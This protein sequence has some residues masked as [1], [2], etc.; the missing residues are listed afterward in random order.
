MLKYLS[1]TAFF[2]AS[3]TSCVT[4]ISGNVGEI[5]V[6]HEAISVPAEKKNT[7]WQLDG[8]YYVKAYRQQYDKHYTLLK[9][10]GG[11][12]RGYSFTGRET[13]P[14]EE[15]YCRVNVG[16][17]E[18]ELKKTRELTFL[19]IEDVI[20][21]NQFNAKKAKPVARVN[22][23]GRDVVDDLYVIPQ[24]SNRAWYGYATYPLILGTVVLDVAFS[25]IPVLFSGEGSSDGYYD[26]DYSSDVYVDYSYTTYTYT[27]T[28]PTGHKPPPHG[29]PSMPD[30]GDQGAHKPGHGHKPGD[31][32]HGNRLR[33][34]GKPGDAHHGSRPRPD[35]KQ[36]N[37][38]ERPGHASPG[39]RPGGSEHG[40]RPNRPSGGSDHRPDPKPPPSGGG[41]SRPSIPPPAPAPSIPTPPPVSKPAGEVPNSLP[42]SI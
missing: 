15:I 25:I 24:S 8:Q 39:G 33:P 6:S 10:L 29:R 5:G 32:Q 27:E 2:L 31:G 22:L 38:P 4:Q 42:N 13:P 1:S 16:D 12:D 21:A 36:G 23:E 30:R 28:N 9:Q 18:K 3:A 7:V 35:G 14:P 20:E 26:D 17:F 37:H 34:G 41:N 40:T 11:E 19:E